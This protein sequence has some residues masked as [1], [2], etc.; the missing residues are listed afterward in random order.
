MKAVI[1]R[2]RHATLSIGGKQHAQIGAGLL[3]FLGIGY[4][5]STED[6]QYLVKKIT[7]L[8]IFNDEAG[9][10]NLNIQTIQGELLLVS[11]FTLWADTRKGNR[12]SYIRAAAPNLSLPLYNKA[13]EA[14]QQQLGNKLQSGVF[15]ADM[16]IE[17]LNDGPVTIIIDSQER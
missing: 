2:V 10:M 5:D 6:I 13:V 4:D 17:L 14:F 3:V 7:Q 8:R 12:P 1:Q 15:G 11:Q 16:Q 9:T